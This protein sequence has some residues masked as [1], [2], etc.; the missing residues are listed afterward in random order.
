ML[1][2][3]TIYCDGCGEAVCEGWFFKTLLKP[4]CVIPF[5]DHLILLD[6]GDVYCSDKRLK[7]EKHLCVDC[8]NKLIT[9]LK[10]VHNDKAT[11]QT[12]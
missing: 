2:K 9:K 5:Y 4:Y 10:E 3:Q 8:Y 11:D 12:D 1:K 6:G 7:E